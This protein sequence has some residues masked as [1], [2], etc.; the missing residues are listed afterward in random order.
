MAKV[1]AALRLD[2]DVLRQLDAAA[3]R[4]GRSR[5]DLIEDSIRR[6]LAGQL[7]TSVFAAVDQSGSTE[8]TEQEA[9]AIGYDEL[10]EA[11][12]D[13]QGSPRASLHRS[14]H[15]ARTFGP[16]MSSTPASSLRPPC[17]PGVH[18]GASSKPPLP[19]GLV[20]LSPITCSANSVTSCVVR[21]SGAGSLSSTPTPLFR[22][23]PCSVNLDRGLHREAAR[24]RGRMSGDTCSRPAP[25]GRSGNR[26]GLTHEVPA[27]APFGEGGLFLDRVQAQS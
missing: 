18:R 27:V 11:R 8:L 20:L 15:G 1:E 21:S 7:L 2:D 13:P 19:V 22:P 10:D 3:G 26:P 16:G 12:G 24:I 25:L 14:R 9:L 6:D 17:R 4:L 23:L 5:D